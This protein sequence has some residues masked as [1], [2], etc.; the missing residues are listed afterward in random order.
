MTATPMVGSTFFGLDISQ[1]ATRLLS[2]RRRISKRVLLLEFG[3]ASLLVA[4][5]TLTQAGVQLS[6]VSSFSLPPEALDRGVPAEPL[7]MA[8]FIQDFCSENKIPA[9]RAAVVLPPELAFQRLLELP[10]SLTTAQAHEYVLNPSNG[11][12]IPFPLTQTDFDLFPVST[13]QEQPQAGDQCAYM[14]TAIPQVLVDPILEMLQAADLELQLLELGSHSQL[15][16]HAAELSTLAPQHIDLVLELL[17]DCSNLMLVS[18][19]GLL[20]SE[21][22]AAIRNLPELDLEP[23]QL[24]VAFESGFSAEDL[25]LKDESYLPLSELDLRVLVA[26]LTASLER[27]H[28]TFPD[29]QIQRLILTGVNSAHPLLAELMSEMLGLQVLWAGSSATPGLAGL[30][31]DGLLL[32]SALSRLIGLALGLL[33]HEQLLACSLEAPVSNVQASHLPNDVVAFVDPV[34]ESAGLVVQEKP[35]DVEVVSRDSDLTNR[36]SAEPEASFEVAFP[37]QH[38]DD[39]PAPPIEITEA[40]M[41]PG[42]SVSPAGSDEK[43]L[44]LVVE[45]MSFG[46]TSAQEQSVVPPLAESHLDSESSEQCDVSDDSW[47]SIIVFRLAM[48]WRSL[49]MQN[50]VSLQVSRPLKGSGHPLLRNIRMFSPSIRLPNLRM[51]LQRGHRLPLMT[52][53]TSP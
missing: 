9:H 4:E 29:A 18:C 1:F 45:D 5:A 35:L 20:G 33:P 15:R 26:D 41:L 42:P 47:P 7:K 48:P 40:E 34:E 50:P 8:R 43:P 11:I 38:L 16:L 23:D 21:R 28:H 6:H 36:V 3:P 13:P 2:M 39:S 10:A 12:Q 19:S 32:K 44:D 25:L 17:P 22:V 31:L 53:R 14:L 46:S 27:F 24:A 51:M 37:I 49:L 52:S 30:S